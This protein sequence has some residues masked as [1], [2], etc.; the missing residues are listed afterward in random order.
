MVRTR[1]KSG[2]CHR[3]PEHSVAVIQD[4]VVMGR[5][6]VSLWVGTECRDGSGQSVVM[7]RDRVSLWVG[8]ECRYGSGQR[9]V[10]GRDRVS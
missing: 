8:T 9:V 10:V 7:G 6:R 3:E 2:Q 1:C 4:S 5:D